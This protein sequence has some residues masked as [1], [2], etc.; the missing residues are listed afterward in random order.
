MR[1][2]REPVS[3]AS[4]SS[5]DSSTRYCTREAWV[6]SASQGH[7]PGRRSRATVSM[8]SARPGHGSPGDGSP[9]CSRCCDIPPAY[10]VATGS[11]QQQ[12][13]TQHTATNV[14]SDQWR[15]TTTN[16]RRGR[17]VHQIRSAAPP[18]GGLT[19]VGSV[20]V[21]RVPCRPSTRWAHDQPN[22]TAICRTCHSLHAVGSYARSL[23]TVVVIP[24]QGEAR[25][26][27]DCVIRLSDTSIA[28]EVFRPLVS[29]RS[30]PD[31]TSLDVTTGHLLTA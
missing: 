15:A 25:E 4:M 24:I 3:I 14:G 27:P 19:A 6:C 8:S 9:P 12:T 31:T 1:S 26:L 21:I 18:R 17:T 11:A 2:S 16:D 30:V 22:T 28:Q 10:V 23:R 20:T 13:A 29:Q 7:P 5:Q